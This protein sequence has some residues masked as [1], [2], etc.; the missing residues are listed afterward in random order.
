MENRHKKALILLNNSA[1]TGKAGLNTWLIIKKIAEK[2]YEP[3]V[4]PIL[5]GTDLVSENILFAYEGEVDLVLCSGGDGTLNHVVQGLMGLRAKPRLAYLPA[6][7]TNDFARTLGIPSD[8]DKALD[9]ATQDQTFR[10]DVGR[11][12]GRCFNYVAA[13]GAF[14]AVSYATDQ[15][16]K[17]ILGHAAYIVSAVSD[18][19]ENM[20]YSRRI[21]I[22][23][24]DFVLEDDYIFG[25]VCNS[26][27]VAGFSVFKDMDV[28]LD[29]G[30]MEIL[31]IKTP[32]T[33][34]DLQ[35]ILNAV[36]RG[37]TDDPF[38][39]FRHISNARFLSESSI[40]WTVDGEYGG[41]FK[42]T[43]IRIEQQAVSIM[44]C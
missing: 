31:L 38:L 39:T 17:N 44:R 19:Y 3:I 24:D 18:L 32:K 33:A 1:G 8:F 16:L 40:A 27:Y 6:G 2:G 28:R 34:A 36:Q 13:F 11:L 41:S 42:E 35:G 12:N 26:A 4:Y 7:S 22:E 25:V 15:Q 20:R 14:S 10:Y 37:T 29:D 5:P 9:M 21:R 43:E 23:A 30:K